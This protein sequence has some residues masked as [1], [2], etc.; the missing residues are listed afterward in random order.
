[1]LRRALRISLILF[2][3]IWFGVVLPGHRRGLVSLSGASTTCCSNPAAPTG[4][5]DRKVPVKA[6]E[7]AICHFMATLDLPIATDVSLPGLGDTH[8]SLPVERESFYIRRFISTCLE[9]GPPVT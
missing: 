8:L 1:M 5:V 7:C 9:R 2:V 3:A 6:G 4:P